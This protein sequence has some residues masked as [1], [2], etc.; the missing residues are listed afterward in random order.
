LVAGVLGGSR[1]YVDRRFRLLRT[2]EVC[3]GTVKG[4]NA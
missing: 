3:V 4:K 2:L 1:L